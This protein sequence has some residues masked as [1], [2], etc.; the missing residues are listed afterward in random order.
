MR[1]EKWDGIFDGQRATQTL[2][3]VP[4]Q[5]TT[6]LCSSRLRALAP[7]RC[8]L[9]VTFFHSDIYNTSIPSINHLI[10]SQV[11]IDRMAASSVKK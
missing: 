5:E 11:E 9:L 10:L 2:S 3:K 7:M 6:V 8:K 4:S 1:L